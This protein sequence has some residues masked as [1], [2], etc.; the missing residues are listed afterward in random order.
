MISVPFH[1]SPSLFHTRA[2]NHAV[3]PSPRGR[4]ERPKR[5]ERSHANAGQ[6][7]KSRSAGWGRGRPKADLH[8]LFLYVSR[9]TERGTA[10]RGAKPR[11][12]PQAGRK[13]GWAARRRGGGRRGRGKPPRAREGR[14]SGRERGKPDP[15]GKPNLTTRTAARGRGKPE[16]PSE[17]APN[18]PAGGKP[19][20]PNA[21]APPR[22]PAD[23][24]ATMGLSLFF[25]GAKK[26]GQISPPLT[27]RITSK[28][29]CSRALNQ[30]ALGLHPCIALSSVG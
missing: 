3:N 7:A 19:E 10:W 2:R 6:A 5:R 12:P 29:M 20:P 30:T 13:G 15:R 17:R 18:R 4:A 23:R 16:P 8:Q 22:R 25:S 1:T 11:E 27:D 24:Q 14:R 21:H 28:L 26:E 9:G